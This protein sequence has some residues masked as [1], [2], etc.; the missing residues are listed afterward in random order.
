MSD[1]QEPPTI[2]FTVL[3][4]VVLSSAALQ[5][6]KSAVVV[7]AFIGPVVLVGLVLWLLLRRLIIKVKH[8][9]LERNSN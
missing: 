7:I 8:S 4:V 5:S 3:V 9:K 6:E 2:A 1:M